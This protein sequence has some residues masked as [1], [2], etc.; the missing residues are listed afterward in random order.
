MDEIMDIIGN[1][2]IFGVLYG[3][4]DEIG[5]WSGHWVLGIGGAQA[6]GHVS[7]VVSNDPSMEIRRIQ[8]YDE[9]RGNYVGD[10]VPWRPWAETAY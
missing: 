5:D 8:S 2:D 10:V 1:N 3:N 4:T 6:P 9:F 7:L